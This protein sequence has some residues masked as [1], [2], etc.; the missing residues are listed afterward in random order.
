MTDIRSLRPFFSPVQLDLDSTGS[1]PFI[2][3]VIF[4]IM[5]VLLVVKCTTRAYRIASHSVLVLDSMAIN[6][7]TDLD[8]PV[9]REMSQL[10][11]V[12]FV[13]VPCASKPAGFCM[14]DNLR[15]KDSAR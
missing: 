4:T 6:K 1:V 8:A 14:K 15:L 2:G 3:E 11:G 13:G 12:T 7:Y 9:K 10:P 5:L